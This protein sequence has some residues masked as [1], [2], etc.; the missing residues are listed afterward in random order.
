MCM[1]VALSNCLSCG[2][3]G[4]FKG[5]AVGYL[6]EFVGNVENQVDNAQNVM[7]YDNTAD[8]ALITSHPKSHHCLNK[9]YNQ[10]WINATSSYIRTTLV[11]R[12]YCHR[13]WRT[14]LNMIH[15]VYTLNTV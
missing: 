11:L 1:M 6:G 15:T 10:Q 4:S 3:F 5:G 2:C 13:D 7:K 14:H 8:K 12:Q 9:K